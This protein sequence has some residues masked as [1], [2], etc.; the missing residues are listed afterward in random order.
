MS[1]TKAVEVVWEE[2]P[3]LD[4]RPGKPRYA[5][6]LETLKAHPDRWGRIYQG[7]IG[8]AASLASRIRKGEG[9]FGDMPGSFEACTRTI[10]G[11]TRVYAKWIAPNSEEKVDTPA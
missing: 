8:T 5:D 2:P 11:K 9:A 1:K 7:K 4:R 3:T 10:N 6:A